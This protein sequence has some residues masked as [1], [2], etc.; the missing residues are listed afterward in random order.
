[1][2]EK[3]QKRLVSK[4]EYIQTMTKKRGLYAL[5]A[6]VLVVGVLCLLLGLLVAI[7]SITFLND[8]FGL[9]I[10]EI[11]I[12]A[13]L[14][15]LGITLTCLWVWLHL[16]ADMLENV[17]PITRHNTGDLPAVETLLRHSALPPSH[18]QSELLRAALQGSE[19]PP[20]ELLRGTNARQ[21]AP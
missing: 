10:R 13:I 9:M 11:G 1:M 18:H 4:L 6:G 17:A 5:S 2:H 14:A 12:G 16:K 8:R 21:E 20:Q 19:T 3:P 15:I 7:I